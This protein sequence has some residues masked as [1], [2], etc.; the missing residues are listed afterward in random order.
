MGTILEMSDVKDAPLVKMTLPGL[1]RIGDRLTLDF[2]IRRRKGGRTE[3]LAVRG[4]VRVIQATVDASGGI[5]AQRLRVE[6]TGAIPFV[7]RAVK[8]QPEWKRRLPPTHF[9][10]TEVY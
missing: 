3:V 4:D 6:N 1:L 7:W 8:N 9:E 2:C 5:L 10:P